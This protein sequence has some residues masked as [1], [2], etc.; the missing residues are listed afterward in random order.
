MRL[1]AACAMDESSQTVTYS[2]GTQESA[3]R[4][5]IVWR[6]NLRIVWGLN[7]VCIACVA[8]SLRVPAFTPLVDFRSW[9][10]DLV[11]D[12]SHLRELYTFFP[13]MTDGRS[14]WLA[15][16]ASVDAAGGEV[17]HPALHRLSQ[18]MSTRAYAFEI[19]C[20]LSPVGG[21]SLYLWCT[22]HGALVGVFRPAP[23]QPPSTRYFLPSARMLAPQ[24]RHE[25]AGVWSGLL[26]VRIPE[27]VLDIV[28]VAFQSESS[29]NIGVLDTSMWPQ[30]LWCTPT[31]MAIGPL[32]PEYHQCVI[33]LTAMG[34]QDPNAHQELRE[35]AMFMRARSMI[36]E[37]SCGTRTGD[38][39]ILNLIGVHHEHFGDCLIGAFRLQKTAP[40]ASS[41]AASS[42]RKQVKKEPNAASNLPVALRAL[43]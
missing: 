18:T 3:A 35:F 12:T 41:E 23:H 36:F 5:K 1:E 27:R 30:S 42:S 29:Q 31:N 32:H 8:W 17:T 24:S 16:F 9:P 26:Q 2:N 38:Q 10:R 14:Q 25:I 43:I 4:S 40:V 33:R 21:G 34:M 6:G 20:G 19:Q 11:C 13:Q 39:M 7:E 28:V 15:R 22:A 37:L